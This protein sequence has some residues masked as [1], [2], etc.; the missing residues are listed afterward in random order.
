MYRCLSDVISFSVVATILKQF[1][2]FLSY[3]DHDI[4]LFLLDKEKKDLNQ[5]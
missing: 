1:K 2:D 5:C 3:I 4:S